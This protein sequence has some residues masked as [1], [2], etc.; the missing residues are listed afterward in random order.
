QDVDNEVH[1]NPIFGHE[2]QIYRRTRQLI[3]D[4]IDGAP[5]GTNERIS[6]QFITGTFIA[7]PPGKFTGVGDKSTKENP[8][9]MFEITKGW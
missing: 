1:P 2:A 5:V 8:E 7:V 3:E 4:P 6:F 9:P